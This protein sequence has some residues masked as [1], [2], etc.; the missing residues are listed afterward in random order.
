[1]GFTN[2]NVGWNQKIL[3]KI[4]EVM[5]KNYYFKNTIQLHEDDLLEYRNIFIENDF[6]CYF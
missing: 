4:N 2:L 3:I 6:D 5:N 1:M